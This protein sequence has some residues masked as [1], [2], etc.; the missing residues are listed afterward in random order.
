MFV[1]LF[2]RCLAAVNTLIYPV[3]ARAQS[4]K[5]KVLKSHH[6]THHHTTMESSALA[7][8][9]LTPVPE[10]T[11]ED[12]SSAQNNDSYDDSVGYS[13]LTDGSSGGGNTAME[14]VKKMTGGDDTKHVR[15]WKY[16]LVGIIA[17]VG[18]IVSL[19]IKTYLEHQEK[20][21]VDNSVSCDDSK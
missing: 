10:A 18:A 7:G 15:R 4:K 9:A 21:E 8:D 1:C 13:G 20:Q 16:L 17:T 2:S 3:L 19:G 5:S 11:F 6:T 14:E 12:S